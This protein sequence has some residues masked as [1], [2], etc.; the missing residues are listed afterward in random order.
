MFSFGIIVFLAGVLFKKANKKIKLCIFGG[1]SRFF[2][3]GFL[4]NTSSMY[5]FG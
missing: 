1:I 3:Y 2:I 4:M 5:M